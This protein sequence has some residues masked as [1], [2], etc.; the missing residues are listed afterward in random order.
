MSTK[1]RITRALFLSFPNFQKASAFGLREL[2]NKR[3]LRKISH[4]GLSLHRFI[5]VYLLKTY[6]KG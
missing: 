2:N 4:K 6:E 1:T 3:E 5:G